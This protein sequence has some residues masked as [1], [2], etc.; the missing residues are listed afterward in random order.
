MEKLRPPSA[1]QAGL[2]QDITDTPYKETLD[3]LINEK[4]YKFDKDL[5]VFQYDWRKDI[6]SNSDLLNEKIN[7]ILATASAGIK[8]DIIAHSMG[9]LVA[10]E[11]IKNAVNAQKVDTLI[12]IGTPH[13]GTP[14]FLAHLLYNKCLKIKLY[15]IFPYCAVNGYEVNK[16]VQNFPGAF[17]VLP[18]CILC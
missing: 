18:K 17:E 13:L 7:A 2:N 3:Y 16:L 6:V 5:F 9:G 8:V 10:R 14:T 11:Y 1:P 15:G 4:D 12:E